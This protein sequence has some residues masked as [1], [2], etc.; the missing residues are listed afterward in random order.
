MDIIV[1]SNNNPVNDMTTPV[2]GLSNDLTRLQRLRVVNVC[3]VSDCC[4]LSK[5]IFMSPTRQASPGRL[6]MQSRRSGSW[7]VH[8]VCKIVS[9]VGGRAEEMEKNKCVVL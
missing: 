2:S 8:R 9:P 3:L 6:S 1:R 4:G 5:W 7:L